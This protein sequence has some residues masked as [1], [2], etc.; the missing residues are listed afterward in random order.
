MASRRCTEL[1]TKAVQQL[2]PVYLRCAEL[3]SN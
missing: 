3:S 1:A 2:K